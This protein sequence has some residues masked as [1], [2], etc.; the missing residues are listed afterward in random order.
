[1]NLFKRQPEEPDIE[2]ENSIEGER[3]LSSVNRGITLQNKLTN[4]AV[5]LGACLFAGVLLYKYYAGMYKHY[6]EAKTAPKDA[7]RTLATTTLPPLSMPEPAP[8]EAPV[9][10]KETD[11]LPPLK[12]S[13]DL[14]SAAKPAPAGTVS[15]QQPVRSQADMVRDRRLKR[16]VR[17]SLDTAGVASSAVASETSAPIDTVSTG[18]SPRKAPASLPQPG[19]YPA[20]RAYML[21]DPTL[22]M[23]RGKVIPCTVVPA[24]D[25]TLTGTVTCVTAVDATSADNKVSLMDRGTYCV[26]KQGGGV[27][28]GQRRVGIIWQRCET[29]QHVLVPLDSDAADS[30]GRTG[31]PGEVDNHFWD[32][33]GSAIALS[34]ITDV[35]PYLI[36]TA[37]RGNGNTTIGFPTITGPQEVMS[38][39]LKST[40]AIRPTI[41][42]SQASQVLIYLAGDIDFRDVYELE[43]KRP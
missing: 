36:A 12:A 6:Q 7:T 9:I 43:R 8:V 31:T 30:L 26:G 40:V 27:M 41:T 11:K 33:F 19:G 42:A 25:T 37:Q 23:T 39:V 4:W 24:I 17:F 38:E 10:A 18:S 29:P 34:L 5:I 3:V 15:G 13:T 22:M 32:R 14:A 21:P 16:E 2:D 1:M 35:G 20:A 28:H